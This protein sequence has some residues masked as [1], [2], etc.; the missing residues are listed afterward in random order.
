MN[1]KT[2]SIAEMRENYNILVKI[3]FDILI[4]ERRSK[5]WLIL[6]ELTWLIQ[7]I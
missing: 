4:L 5:S 2:L 6:V 7:K 3:N 1:V